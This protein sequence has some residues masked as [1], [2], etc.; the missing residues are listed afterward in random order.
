MRGPT[1]CAGAPSSSL[2][3][4]PPP[5]PAAPSPLCLD[6]ALPHCL[7]LLSRS[8]GC[9]RAGRGSGSAP[10]PLL[11]R[12]ACSAARRAGGGRARFAF[13]PGAHS[14]SSQHLR[15]RRTPPPPRRPGDARVQGPCCVATHGQGPPAPA[16]GRAAAPPQPSHLPL[17][18]SLLSPR[19]GPT[20]ECVA[21]PHSR[22]RG[23]PQAPAQPPSDTVMQ[24]LRAT[25]FWGSAAACEVGGSSGGGGA[26][27]GARRRARPMRA[28][29]LS[30]PPLRARG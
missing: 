11:R 17:P 19:V 26:W 12:A 6:L 30:P 22:A 24:L 25:F 14:P 3:C 21:S 23:A 29:A 5:P 1:G 16:A 27:R 10:P 9:Q 8:A 4:V 28:R 20:R 13:W 7:A 15:A 2:L 18:P